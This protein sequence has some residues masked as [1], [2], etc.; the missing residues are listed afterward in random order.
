MT[1][2]YS[3][4]DWKMS[5]NDKYMEGLNDGPIEVVLRQSSI[6]TKD[7]KSQVSFPYL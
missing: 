5:S 2:I 3:W 4:I 7:A 1:K 6:N